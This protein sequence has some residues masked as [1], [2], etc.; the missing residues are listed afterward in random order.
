[1]LV[2]D[3]AIMYVKANILN[4]FFHYVNENKADIKKSRRLDLFRH[5]ITENKRDVI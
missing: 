1:M 3:F 5:H 4:S 2:P